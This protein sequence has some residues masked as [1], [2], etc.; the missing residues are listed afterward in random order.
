MCGN[1]EAEGMNTTITSAT[2]QSTTS[3]SSPFALG[4]ML[5]GKRVERWKASS[6]TEDARL[7]E[8]L[9][10]RAVR[11]VILSSDLFHE[12]VPD[13]WID[14]VFAV[15][16]LAPQHVFQVLT[17]RSAR[18]REY[19]SGVGLMMRVTHAGARMM[20]DGDGAYSQLANTRWP[21]PNVWLGVSA[22]DQKRA[23]ER[24]PDLLATPAAVRF[25]SAEPLLGPIS[26]KRRKDHGRLHSEHWDYLAGVW[27][28]F[29]GDH[30]RSGK[31]PKLDWIIVGGES[32]PGAR[33][34]DN[35]WAQSIVDQ[36]KAAGVA[37]FVKQLSS[38]GP[39]AIKDMALF[40]E[41]LRVREMPS[42]GHLLDGIKHNA[43]P[44]VR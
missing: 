16:A 17:K 41:G 33:P 9:K 5:S 26:F 38:G 21:L 12:D 24:I 27:Q 35:A 28:E 4:A 31:I 10:M 23:D 8:P 14:R 25:A 19:L 6:P 20:D 32:G 11:H 40:P 29:D 34:M 18:M 36:C 44:E 3:M 13:E 15:M 22:E 2:A 39:K 1:R 43:M 42:A 30:Y 7:V 37:V